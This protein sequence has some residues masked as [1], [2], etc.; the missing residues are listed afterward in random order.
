[1]L[2]LSIDQL[3]EVHEADQ[4]V[5]AADEP[6]S[7]GDGNVITMVDALHGSAADSNVDGGEPAEADRARLAAPV[8]NEAGGADGCPSP[9]R[10][11]ARGW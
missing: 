9:R 1:M 5:D 7:A 11:T 6:A 8:W 10:A 3:F 4:T 2:Q